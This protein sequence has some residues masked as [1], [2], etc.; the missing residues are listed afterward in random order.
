[1]IGNM[2][3]KKT[4]NTIC[5][6]TWGVIKLIRLFDA[7][8]AS[9][10]VFVSF[11]I[12]GKGKIPL[13]SDIVIFAMTST[14]MTAAIGM[15]TND[16]VDYPSDLEKGLMRKPFVSK[17]VTINE[18]KILIIILFALGFIPAL[19][20]DL[21]PTVMIKISVLYYLLNV[22]FLF[23]YNLYLKNKVI[24]GNIMIGYLTLAIFIYGDLLVNQKLTTPIILL[25]LLAFVI[26]VSREI[27]K[28][29]GSVNNG[30]LETSASIA[31]KYGIKTASI[32]STILLLIAILLASSLIYFVNLGPIGQIG[33]TLIQIA[34]AY[35]A[36]E[37][38]IRPVKKTANTIKTRLVVL[39]NIVMLF[40]ILDYLF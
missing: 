32:I 21:Q 22:F 23:M 40:F 7:V 24:A 17:Q 28:H 2:T 4:W 35:T 34:L 36:I 8:T 9:M 27:I 13:P 10:A 18:G 1:M 29:I 19:L 16:I 15:I 6:K 33:V 14:F 37:I 5:I 20:I 25:G 39:S 30:D 26:T 12:A 31:L 3:M 38:L 11:F